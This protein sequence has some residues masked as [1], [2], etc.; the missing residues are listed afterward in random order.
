MLDSIQIF[1]PFFALVCL[2]WLAVQGQL[3]TPVGIRAL[4]TYVL[5]FGLPAMVFLLAA[6]G[7]L[8]GHT[9]G[10]MLLAYGV[11][12]TA[13]LLIACMVYAKAGLPRPHA[14]LLALATVFPNTGFLGL[15]LLTA[16]L[17][18][19][20]AGAVMATLLVD[21]L[22]LSSWGLVWA[23][24][25]TTGQKYA[26]SQLAQSLHGALRN[27]L[28]WAMAAGLAWHGTSWHLPMAFDNTLELLGMAASPTA[29]FALGG[30]LHKKGRTL[31][32]SPDVQGAAWI[33]PS[34]VV[35][36]LVAHPT[37]VWLT[38]TLLQR[39]GWPLAPDTLVAL[40]MAA[41]LPSA[42]NV[43]LLAERRQA[44]AARVGQ[45][46]WWTTLLSIPTML[47]W[48]SLVR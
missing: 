44:D 18:T 46:I 34:G 10:A 31:P 42:S 35:M 12:G 20:A 23:S 29:L 5:F 21:V 4:N 28:L 6:R 38:G 37:L 13:L 2:G 43:L 41:A 32:V 36:K 7:A 19:T 27:P 17:G 26:G 25:S 9:L 47:L 22:W 33:H 15:P 30:V 45:L 11:G 40:T 1:L 16:L 39:Y 14:G 48:G 3:L 24:S 8:T